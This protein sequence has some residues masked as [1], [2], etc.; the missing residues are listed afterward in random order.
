MIRHSQQQPQIQTN[1]ICAT[2]PNK[3]G[4]QGCQKA[5]TKVGV[6]G[7]GGGGVAEKWT[8]PCKA[9]VAQLVTYK[10]VMRE[11]WSSG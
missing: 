1:L 4:I 6:V 2:L 9:K 5:E 10:G 8:E 3:T 11:A 7:G